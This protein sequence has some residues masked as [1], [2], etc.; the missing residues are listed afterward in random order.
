MS[1]TAVVG[2]YTRKCSRRARHSSG[3]AS[4]FAFG[5][6]LLFHV[7]V[8]SARGPEYPVMEKLVQKVVQKYQTSSCQDLAQQKCQPPVGKEAQMQQRAVHML[9]NDPRMRTE[10]INRVAAPI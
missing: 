7:G 4:L 10:F 2:W 9:H 5:S 6:L 8:A 3:R 1:T